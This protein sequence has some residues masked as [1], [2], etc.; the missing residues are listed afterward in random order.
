M[1][2]VADKETREILGRALIVANTITMDLIDEVTRI[3]ADDPFNTQLLDQAQTLL[4]DS[5]GLYADHFLYTEMAS[6]VSGFD[7]AAGKFPP[8]LI[9]EFETGVRQGPPQE[10]P[11]EPPLRFRGIFGDGAPDEVRYPKIEK[12]AESLIERQI[13]TRDEFDAV[14]DAAKQKA[15]TIAG[16][17][18]RDTINRVRE[19]LATDIAEGTSLDGFRTKL[20]QHLET[21]PIGPGHLETVYRTNVQAAFRDGRETLTSNPVVSEAFPYQEYIPLRDGRVRETHLALEKLGLDGTGVY[22]RDDPFWDRFTPPWDFNCRCGVNLLTIQKAAAKGVREAQEWL[23]TGQPPLYP[24]WRD[25]AIPFPHN[26]GFG[27]RG[28]VLVGVL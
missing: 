28:N 7:W 5:M 26:P 15:F 19:T 3:L 11:S 1:P 10:P 9:K 22:R 4:Q 20:R 12:A 14:Q 18:T 23:E 25:Q 6:W 2:D 16:D 21:S 8:W 17:L 24:E 27:S 13:L